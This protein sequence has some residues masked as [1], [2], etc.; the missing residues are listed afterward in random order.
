MTYLHD[1]DPFALKLWGDFGIRWYGLS[2][3]MGFFLGYLFIIWLARK[4]RTPVLPQHV[5]DFV[6]AVA[7]GCIIGGRLGYCIFYNP[8]LLYSFDGAFPFWGVLQI[9]K[10]GMA[11]HGGMIGMVVS[12]WLF[13][14]KHDLP[15]T[16]LFDLTIF[17]STLGIFF[18]RLA[19]FVNGELLGRPSPP[20]F[21]FS[22]KFPQEIYDWPYYA[23]EKLSLL[24]KIVPAV[25]ISPEQFG[26]WVRQSGIPQARQSIENT[27]QLIVQA[28]QQD[29]SRVIE[30]LEPLLVARYPSQ[31]IAACLEGLFIFLILFVVWRK[32][33]KPG[34]ITALFFCLYAVFRV[35]GEQFRMPDL[36]IGFQLFGLTRGQWLSL[37]LLIIGLICLA[38]WNSRKAEP[39]GGWSNKATNIS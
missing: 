36:H 2:Y 37:A 39:M 6:F 14:R 10:G 3:L 15:I 32:P 31:L 4:G 11:S 16:H 25:G 21:P 27:L 20:D 22:V 23:P 1:L 5:G 19:N 29:N 26:G 30:A 24:D 28:V 13:G 7:L 8:S 33:Q 17:G 12:C 34:I 38:Y 9:N 35:V 18:G